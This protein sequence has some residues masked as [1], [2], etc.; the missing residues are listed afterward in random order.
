MV[1]GTT[2]A[3]DT[4]GLQ[5][6]RGIEQVELVPTYRPRLDNCR[7][8]AENRNDENCRGIVVVVIQRPQDQARDLKNIEGMECLGLSAI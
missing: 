7:G 2:L 1:C 3:T 5:E 8:D 6:K 4:L